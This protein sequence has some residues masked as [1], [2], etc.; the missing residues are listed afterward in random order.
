MLS[1]L[2]RTVAFFYQ[3]SQ[4]P[5]PARPL[6]HTVVSDD[7][8]LA[9]PVLVHTANVLVFAV[10]NAE[11]ACRSGIIVAAEY[12]ELRVQFAELSLIHI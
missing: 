2:S 10:L 3:D 6:Q 1:P 4:N 8:I 11:D 12:A 5:A 9:N 7:R